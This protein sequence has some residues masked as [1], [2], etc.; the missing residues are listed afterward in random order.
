MDIN[1]SI[2]EKIRLLRVEGKYGE[3]Y[4]ALK[5]LIESR[6][7]EAILEAVKLM[8]LVKQFDIAI[9]NFQFLLLNNKEI[10]KDEPELI[11]RLETLKPGLIPFDILISHSTREG[12]WVSLYREKKIDTMY[13]AHIC[14]C[15]VHNFG[16]I[17][18]NISN[19]C[20]SCKKAYIIQ[21]VGTLLVHKEY[22]CPHCF[23]RQMI[24]FDFIKAF[25]ENNHTN[26]IGGNVSNLNMKICHMQ[27]T[28]NESYLNSDIPSLV[29]Y[30]NQDFIFLMNEMIINHVLTKNRPLEG[31]QHRTD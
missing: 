18:Y 20:M 19:I 30:L 10:M 21:I 24:N 5:N 22:F 1:K 7:P 11:Y 25:I 27:K 14:G 6:N 9:N 2:L 8:I 15:E 16:H 17:V 23:A 4:T 12:E 26:L 3:V 28:I 29:S 31:N 13:P